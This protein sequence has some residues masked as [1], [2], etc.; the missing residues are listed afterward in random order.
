MRLLELRIYNVILYKA[1]KLSLFVILCSVLNVNAKQFEHPYV[2]IY[3]EGVVT[4]NIKLSE[5]GWQAI[6]QAAGYT[7]VRVKAAL[8][9]FKNKSYAEAKVNIDTALHLLTLIKI[10]T[11][12]FQIREQ[13]GDDSRASNVQSLSIISHDE[14]GKEVIIDVP[15]LIA[16]LVNAQA[17]LQLQQSE[18]TRIFLENALESASYED[19]IHN[20]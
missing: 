3:T 18:N 5:E 15:L 19:A 12:T 8:D 1:L 14:H 4:Q 11:P 9:E 13:V 20:T 6:T 10:A 17:A 16:F 2:R 7:L